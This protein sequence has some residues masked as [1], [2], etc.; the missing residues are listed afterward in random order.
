MVEGDRVVG[1]VTQV[2]LKF[3][4]KTV[5]LTA[6]TFLNGLIHVGLQNYSG[7]RRRSTGDFLGQRLKEL[8]LPQGRLK[9][10]TPPRI[11]GRTINYSILEEQPGDLDPIPCSRMRKHGRRILGSCLAGSRTNTRTH[12]IIRG[13]LDRLADV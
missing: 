8:K 6:G 3:R 12:D 7:G 4:A 10:G 11:D 9:T 5:V 2:G 1:A 13:G